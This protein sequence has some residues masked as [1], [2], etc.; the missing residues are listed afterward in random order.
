MP[1]KSIEVFLHLQKLKEKTLIINNMKV[2]KVF[3]PG[4]CLLA[5]LVSCKEE[6]SRQPQAS[7]YPLLTLTTENRTL[8]TT[9]STVLEGKQYVEVRPQVS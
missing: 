8:S 6:V 9:Y 3:I 2:L 5:G 1:Y 4:L 7:A